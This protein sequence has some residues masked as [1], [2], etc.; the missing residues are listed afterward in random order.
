MKKFLEAISK[1]EE[2]TRKSNTM[3]R[4]E[5]LALAKELDTITDGGDCLC[6]AAGAGY[7]ESGEQRC[8]CVMGGGGSADN[9][10]H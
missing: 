6:V 5:L 1:N 10:V 8:F 9:S 7:H 2:L 4:E 3:T